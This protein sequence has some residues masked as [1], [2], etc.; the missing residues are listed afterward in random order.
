LITL[1]AVVHTEQISGGPRR[2]SRKTPPYN[3]GRT[4]ATNDVD[5]AEHRGCGGHSFIRLSG[6][7]CDQR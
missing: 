1:A 2:S 4:G 3:L 5:R 6:H 7:K